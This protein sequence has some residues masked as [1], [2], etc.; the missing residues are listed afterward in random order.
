M[1]VLAA[2]VRQR[3]QLPLDG[4]AGRAPDSGFGLPFDAGH[5]AVAD[6]R[7]RILGRLEGRCGHAAEPHDLR[8]PDPAAP[9]QAA[10]RIVAVRGPRAPGAQRR[11]NHRHL[12][13]RQSGALRPAPLALATVD[14]FGTG[15]GSGRRRRRRRLAAN[16]RRREDQA[17]GRALAGLADD[18]ELAAMP[19]H[20]MLD[21]R[22]AEAGAARCRAS[23][24]CRPGRSA[25]SGAAGARGRCRC[26]CR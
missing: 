17:E 4:A 14:L 11:R 19:L 25:R 22:Q 7:P 6:R 3:A 2:A 18:V 21:D 20:H 23:G 5:V 9:A 10:G 24:C 16:P 12:P 13:A 1:T 8:V 15:V 26:R